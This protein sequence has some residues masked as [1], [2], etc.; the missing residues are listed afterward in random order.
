MPNCFVAPTVK[1][2]AVQYTICATQESFQYYLTHLKAYAMFTLW[3]KF[4]ATL[5][6]I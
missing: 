4:S 2:L 3:Y 6:T 5:V 1:D